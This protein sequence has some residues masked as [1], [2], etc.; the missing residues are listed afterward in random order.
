M[1]DGTDGPPTVDA[2]ERARLGHW[3]LGPGWMS[4]EVANA[5]SDEPSRRECEYEAWLDR[6]GYPS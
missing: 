5:V 1:F 6:K 2:T 3:A 4:P